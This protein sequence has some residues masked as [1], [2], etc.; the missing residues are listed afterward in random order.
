MYGSVLRAGSVVCGGTATRATLEVFIVAA[1]RA[2]LLLEGGG[3]G[4]TRKV[5]A[6]RHT[7]W[8]SFPWCRSTYE[9]RSLMTR[10]THRSM[11]QR[12]V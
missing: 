10:P 5:I 11:V 12:V 4:D 8:T 3:G 2:P 7:N 1:T 9:Y 6:R